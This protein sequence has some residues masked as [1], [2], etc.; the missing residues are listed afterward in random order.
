M[1][2]RSPFRY[3]KT[4]PEIIRLAVMLYVRFPLSLRNVEDLLHERGVNIS[5]EKVRFWWHRFGPIFA[6]E[7]RAAP[8]AETMAMEKA[9]DRNPILATAMEAKEPR[10][11]IQVRAE[12]STKEKIETAGPGWSGGKVAPSLKV[13]VEALR[14]VHSVC[15]SQRVCCRRRSER[16]V[17]REILADLLVRFLHQQTLEC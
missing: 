1:T 4:S 10:T 6:A 9:V 11:A 2:K 14:L 8:A 12:T 13:S 17:T 3:F 15:F 7:I 5:H 16:I